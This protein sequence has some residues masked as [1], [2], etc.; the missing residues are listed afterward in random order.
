VLDIEASKDKTIDPQVD[1]NPTFAVEA[2]LL[3]VEIQEVIEPVIVLQIVPIVPIIMA[4]AAPSRWLTAGRSNV[5]AAGMAV[6]V[7]KEDRSGLNADALLKL[8][9]S[10]T[11]GMT[12]KFFLICN[13][14][15][16]QLVQCYNLLLQ[17][18]E[19]RHAMKKSDIVLAL[20]IFETIV[21]V[22]G[23]H[24][25]PFPD[26][27]SL[28]DKAGEALSDAQVRTTNCFKRYYRQ[29]YDIQDLQ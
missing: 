1:L 10:S 15:E 28:F 8:Q 5:E 13:S 12:N 18:E 6:A 7:R 14:K 26:T 20:D 22:G 24:P 21:P 25:N 4:V 11:E 9:H 29:A 2:L 19:L 3:E 16:D 17:V 23:T 27:L